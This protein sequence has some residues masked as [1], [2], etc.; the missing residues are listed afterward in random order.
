MASRVSRSVMLI[1]ILQ[2]KEEPPPPTKKYQSQMSVVT[3]LRN[4]VL[5]AQEVLGTILPLI[6]GTEMLG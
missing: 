4:P 5:K 6:E 3:R 1:N 2:H